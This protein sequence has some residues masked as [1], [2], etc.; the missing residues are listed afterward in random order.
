MLSV[1]FGGGH[2]K[3]PDA[4]E[5]GLSSARK[6]AAGHKMAY[7][8]ESPT[9]SVLEDPLFD[10]RFL[11]FLGLGGAGGLGMFGFSKVHSDARQR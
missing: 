11:N 5:V 1:M 6:T 3:P 8:L 4:E 7:L 9:P 10:K 2:W